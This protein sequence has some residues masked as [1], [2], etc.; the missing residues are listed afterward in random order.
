MTDEPDYTKLADDFDQNLRKF[1]E[2]I[3]FSAEG[4]GVAYKFA[5]FCDGTADDILSALRLAA[6]AKEAKIAVAAEREACAAIAE[7]NKLYW[8]SRFDLMGDDP[9]RDI[10]RAKSAAAF[11]IEIGIRARKEVRREQF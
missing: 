1:R 3:N 9:S 10:Y 2:R 11:Q 7:E 8:A 4:R 5:H 6:K